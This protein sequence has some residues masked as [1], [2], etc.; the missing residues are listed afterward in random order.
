MGDRLRSDEQRE[1]VG[2]VAQELGPGRAHTEEPEELGRLRR[3][4]QT[5]QMECDILRPRRSWNTRPAAR[6]AIFEHLEIFYNGQ[7]RHPSPGFLS[8]R[9]F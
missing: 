2:A 6:C 4:N 5:L 1:I 3:E 9:V 8:P 7:R